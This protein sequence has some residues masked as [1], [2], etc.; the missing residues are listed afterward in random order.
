VTAPVDTNPATSRGFTLVAVRRRDVRR[1]RESGPPP[2]VELPPKHGGKDDPRYPSPHALRFGLGFTIDLALHLACAVA[3][4]VA[5][6]RNHALPL[7]VI[8]A[9][10]PATFIAVSV[11]HRIFVQRIV[12]TT[13]GKA[14]TG[15]RYI[16]DD[17]GGPPTLGSLTKAWFTGTLMAILNVLSGF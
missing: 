16:R 10:G 3:V 9:A 17:T 8:L 1:L 14:L 2:G 12:H 4:A 11:I 5:V 7:G 6:S 13:L 15:V